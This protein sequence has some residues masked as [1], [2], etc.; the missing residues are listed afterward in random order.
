M[1]HQ[2]TIQ[3][4][5]TELLPDS[6]KHPSLSHIKVVFCDDQPN[7]N[8]QGVEYE[9]FEQVK[10][11]AIGTPVKMRFLGTTA[12]G[13][14]GSIPIGHIRDMYEE[15]VE[16]VHRLIADVVLYA[17]E[18]PDEVEY[19]AHKWT[20]A[21]AG[22]G[23]A[24]GVSFEM[25]YKDSV[26]KNGVQWIKNIIT[27]AATFVRNPA[28]GNRTAI[29][30]WASDKSISDEEFNAT[31]QAFISETS[32]KN[33]TEGGNNRME[34]EL[35][36]LKAEF[37][38]LK[39]ETAETL[40]TKDEEIKTLTTQV[41]TLTTESSE[42]DTVIAEYKGK[43]LVGERTAVLAEAGITIEVKPE[44]ISKMDEDEFTQY[45]EDLKAVMAAGKPKGGNAAAGKLALAS[46]SSR[47]PRFG[48]GAS[49]DDTVTVEGLKNKLGTLSR[50]RASATAE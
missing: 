37:E 17:E 41:S 16:N 47:L 42:K 49:S 30:A 22:M 9:D 2:F 45:V 15:E 34:E 43:E 33:T 6:W 11:S 29:L 24:P 10:K 13:H 12:G 46:A 26:I 35:K 19:L 4:S 25:S 7:S 21:Q 23:E 5:I 20:E 14:H 32:P 40:A 31:I 1:E 8:N 27:R 18:Y 50:L 38:A 28:Y 3:G 44:R 48:T 39:K 36:T